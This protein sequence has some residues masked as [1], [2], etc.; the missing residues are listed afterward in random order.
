MAVDTAFEIKTLDK[1][2]FDN[3][4]L[5]NIQLHILCSY[6]EAF[7]LPF[8]LSNYKLISYNKKYW[9]LWVRPDET[10]IINQ[11]VKD[12]IALTNEAIGR[13]PESFMLMK[14]PE[15]KQHVITYPFSEKE[16]LPCSKTTGRY[17]IDAYGYCWYEVNAYYMPKREQIAWVRETAVD[18]EGKEA[19]Q[20]L[21]AENRAIIMKMRAGQTNTGSTNK[22][23]K[24]FS[25]LTLGLTLLSSK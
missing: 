1:W 12:G 8:K 17:Y 4:P 6:V 11:L 25:F 23:T 14:M 19:M 3:M 15:Y 20:A 16:N 9:L 10:Q 2:I 7:Q 13:S 18:Y 21:I 5:T 22:K 24:L